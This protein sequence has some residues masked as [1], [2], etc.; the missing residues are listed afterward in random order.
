MYDDVAKFNGV[1]LVDSIVICF[2]AAAVAFFSSVAELN[3]VLY[4]FFFSVLILIMHARK[5]NHSNR[6][7]VHCME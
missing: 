3:V 1:P 2:G 6:K 4:L 7:K 5:N